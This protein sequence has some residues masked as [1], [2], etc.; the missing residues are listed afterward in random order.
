M[1]NLMK[2]IALNLVLYQL[3]G[4][5]AFQLVLLIISL[6]VGKYLL[7]FFFSISALWFITLQLS[8]AHRGR[9]D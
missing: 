2:I 3:F 4:H 1:K 8:Y 5:V 9:T 6:M 7:S